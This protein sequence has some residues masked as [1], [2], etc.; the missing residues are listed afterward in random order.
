MFEKLNLANDVPPQRV[1]LRRSHG[2]LGRC[3]TECLTLNF[4]FESQCLQQTLSM[5]SA[6]LV[7]RFME[8]LYEGILLLHCQLGKT[9]FT[10]AKGLP[11]L[12]FHVSSLLTR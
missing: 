3:G 1:R 2:I 4:T 5:S 8:C 10:V 6:H 7:L 11:K 12:E 9:A